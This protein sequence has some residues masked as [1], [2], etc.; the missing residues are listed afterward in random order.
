MTSKSIYLIDSKLII[1]KWTGVWDFEEYIESLRTFEATNYRIEIN[2]VLHDIC[3]L[4]YSFNLKEI[5]NIIEIKKK[6]VRK[7]HQTVYIT[8]KPQDVVFAQMY[9]ENLNHYNVNHCSTIEKGI[10]LLELEEYS[11]EITDKFEK[12]NS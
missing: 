12:I 10:Q 7:D 2:K 4:E 5:K 11:K 6:Y 8:A 9:S 1:V 3:E